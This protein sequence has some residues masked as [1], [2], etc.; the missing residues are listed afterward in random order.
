MR[1][2]ARHPSANQAEGIMVFGLLAKLT[3]RQ[4]R[5]FSTLYFI[6]ID[7]LSRKQPDSLFNS[8]RV[9][10]KLTKNTHLECSSTL[11]IFDVL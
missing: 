6:R 2:A 4:F 11:T 9:K 8:K 10:V 1:F 5:R 7:L 3:L